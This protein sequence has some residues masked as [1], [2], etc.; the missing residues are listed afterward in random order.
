MSQT[1]LSGTHGSAGGPTTQSA[2]LGPS[3]ANTRAFGSIYK[4]ITGKPIYV[5]LM[6][7]ALTT[8]GSPTA[9]CE[10]YA[11]SDSSSTPTTYVALQSSPFH[12]ASNF[13]MSMFF[14]V[15]PNNYYRAN[16][17]AG[18]GSIVFWIE[19]N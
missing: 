19:W 13:G 16:Y 17:D 3:G 8:A 6:V 7:H 11:Q 2:D 9:G 4:N 12:P 18:T 5:S 1:L 15:M 14:I 10:F